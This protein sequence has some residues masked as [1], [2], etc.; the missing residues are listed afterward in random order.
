MEN[1]SRKDEERERESTAEGGKGTNVMKK[2][3]NKVVEKRKG[4]RERKREG[5][6]VKK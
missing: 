2:N 1:E 5:E 4:M 3:T 6:E